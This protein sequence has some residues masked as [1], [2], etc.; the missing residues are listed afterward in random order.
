MKNLAEYHQLAEL[1]NYDLFLVATIIHNFNDNKLIDEIFT[2]LQNLNL[3]DYQDAISKAL[4]IP[5]KEIQLLSENACFKSESSYINYLTSLLELNNIEF[6]AFR[7]KEVKSK[8][9]TKSLFND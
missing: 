1:L 6:I 3:E 2:D 9:V 4:D 7:K 5:I 8:F